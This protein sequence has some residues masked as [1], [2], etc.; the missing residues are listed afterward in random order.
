MTNQEAIRLMENELR[1][2]QRA[3]ANCCDRN[4]AACDLLE[5]ADDIIK[6]YGMAIKALEKN[7]YNDFKSNYKNPYTEILGEK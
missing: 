2:V 4:C 7:N 1:C 5:E 3:N 6:A